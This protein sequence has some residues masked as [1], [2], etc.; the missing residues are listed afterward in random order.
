MR[1][2]YTFSNRRHNNV[3]TQ[4]A[5]ERPAL[6]HLISKH[7]RSLCKDRYRTRIRGQSQRWNSTQAHMRSKKLGPGLSTD[8]KTFYVF[9]SCLVLTKNL[10]PTQTNRTQPNPWAG[11]PNP[12][13]TLV[14]VVAIFIQS[15]GHGTKQHNTR[16]GHIDSNTQSN[17]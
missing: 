13:A 8:V 15:C 5:S 16:H 1:R 2:P 10:E 9:Y 7:W 11:Q 6:G 12:W 17:K 4:V 14:I 3:S